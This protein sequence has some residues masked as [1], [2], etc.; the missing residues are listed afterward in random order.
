MKAVALSSSKKMPRAVATINLSALQG[1]VEQL[2]QHNLVAKTKLCAV[3][4][5]DGYG[6]GI[7]RVARAALLGGAD[8]LAVATFAEAK[9]LRSAGVHASILLLGP[10]TA[11]ELL[12]AL[13]L[14]VETIAWTNEFVERIIQAG[15][16]A[17]VHVKLD[18]GMGRYG[19][20]DPRHATTLCEQLHAAPG[21]NLVG[22]MTHFATADER[23]SAFFEQQLTCFREWVMPLKKRF[24]SIIAHAANSAATLRTKECHFDMVRPGIALYGIDPFGCSPVDYGLQPVLKLTSYVAAVKA[25]KSGESAGYG[26]RYVAKEPTTVGTIPI[27]YGDGFRRAF[28]NSAELLIGG[29]RYPVVGTVSMDA[30]TVDLGDSAGVAVGDEVVLI[31]VQKSDQVF[32]EE[33]AE[34][35]DTIGYE[36]VCGLTA[37]VQRVYQE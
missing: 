4:K 35:I 21:V 14:N 19:T 29:V 28:S 31:G 6:H 26:R 13:T 8:Q 25:C 22:A 3:I 33:L 27:G 24:P 30:I 10:L 7:E 11:E 2:Y 12:Q 37:R 17:N 15:A 34:R 5:A 16:A 23:G 9:Q 18:S 36:I 20:R 32:A 1:N